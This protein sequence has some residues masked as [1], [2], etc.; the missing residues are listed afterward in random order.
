[1][2]PIAS[3]HLVRERSGRTP[4]VMARLGTDRLRLRTVPGLRFWRLL[5]TGAGS[6]TAP[7]RDLSRSA[8]FAVWDDES[9]LDRFLSEH[10]IA[11]RWRRA[12]EVWHVRLRGLGGHG[13]WRGF[14]VLGAI[15]QGLARGPIAVVT[16]ADI[17]PGAWRA[18]AA[19][20]R[21]VDDEV[22]R[23]DGLID[24]VGIGEAPVGRLGTFSLWESAAAARAF[25]MSMPAHRDVVARTRDELWYSEELFARFEPFGSSGSWNGNDPLARSQDDPRT[26]RWSE[27]D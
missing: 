27:R 22:H 13:S 23:A 9:S 8:V 18:F 12:D 10:P 14:D 25:A 3:F 15:D 26:A 2:T 7:S 1:V 5:G 24:V 17:R 19:A 21:P 16:R 6:D 20:G 11:A 4:I